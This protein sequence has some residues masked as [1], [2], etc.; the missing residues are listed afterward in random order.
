MPTEVTKGKVLGAP[1]ALGILIL[2]LFLLI[3]LSLSP[4]GSPGS[5]GLGVCLLILPGSASLLSSGVNKSWVFKSPNKFWTPILFAS[6]IFPVISSIK[7]AFKSL[8]FESGRCSATL[9]TNSNIPFIRASLVPF[10]K[11]GPSLPPAPFLPLLNNQSSE[12]I[13]VLTNW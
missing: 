4:T 9:L 1:A 6:V 12:D 10:I 8:I 11:S 5:I 2:M 7:E 3:W 13:N